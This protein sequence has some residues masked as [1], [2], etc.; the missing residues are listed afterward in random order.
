MARHV[1]TEHH[2]SWWRSTEKSGILQDGERWVEQALDL[3]PAE[4]NVVTVEAVLAQSAALLMS[5]FPGMETVQ[6]TL[7]M[8]DRNE[9]MVSVDRT[10]GHWAQNSWEVTA[11]LVKK[12]ISVPE[13]NPPERSDELAMGH[14]R[15]SLW[16]IEKAEIVRARDSLG[17]LPRPCRTPVSAFRS[18]VLMR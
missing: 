7:D 16:I 5:A 6:L 1:K 15:W 2:V 9:I 3:E 12:D 14:N 17:G 13:G 8:I 11:G 4:L 18:K 10:L